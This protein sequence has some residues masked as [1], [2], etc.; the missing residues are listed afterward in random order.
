MWIVDPDFDERKRRARS[1]RK[2]DPE[3]E[4]GRRYPLFRPSGH[5]RQLPTPS[6][7]RCPANDDPGEVFEFARRARQEA[8]SALPRRS[9]L[10]SSPV[11]G[12]VAARS[13]R[14][15]SP[16]ICS[17]LIT[18]RSSTTRI[19]AEP[20][21]TP[22]GF[23]ETLKEEFGQD[24]SDLWDADDMSLESF[25]AALHRTHQTCATRRAR[26]STSTFMVTYTT[27]RPVTCTSS[28]KASAI[29]RR[30]VAPP[31]AS[32]WSRTFG[33]SHLAACRTGV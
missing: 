4:D 27:S 30:R 29:R 3:P 15:A 19:A 28:R 12:R 11:V 26:R 13:F 8:R 25:T 31:G 21:F 2:V 24:I 1:F 16:A 10:W 7:R 33:R 18:W 14:S 23:I 9:F 17:I 22:E 32:N 20:A 6:P 5:E